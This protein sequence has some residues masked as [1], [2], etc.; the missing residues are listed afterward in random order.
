[1]VKGIFWKKMLLDT[2]QYS[3]RELQSKEAHWIFHGSLP[4]SIFALSFP[5]QWWYIGLLLTKSQNIATSLIPCLNDLDLH[6]MKE[7]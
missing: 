5:L 6:G 3:L 7:N 1:M 2:K 4:W